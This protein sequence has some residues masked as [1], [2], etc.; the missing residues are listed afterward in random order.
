ML[1]IEVKLNGKLI[2]AAE[3]TN[4]SGLADVSDYKLTWMEEGAPDLGI[5]ASKGEDEFYGYRRKQSVWMMVGLVAAFAT[6][7][8]ALFP[9]PMPKST[10]IARR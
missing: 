2:A 10:P 7:G 1:T 6:R 3:L 8:K 9:A 4:L 5:E